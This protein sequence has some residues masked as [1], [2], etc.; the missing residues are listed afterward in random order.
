MSNKLN[1]NRN[2]YSRK[3][4]M[5]I[6]RI[7]DTTVH[8]LFFRESDPIPHVILGRKIIVPCS[9]FWEWL[10]RQAELNKDLDK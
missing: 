4:I 9:A 6:L 2:V 10:D 1:D 3:D 5:K 8:K 7:T